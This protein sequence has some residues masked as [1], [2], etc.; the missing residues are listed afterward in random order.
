M[1]NGRFVAYYRVSTAKQ[2][3]SGLG[4]EAQQASVRGWLNGGDW[5]LVGELVEV[6]SGKRSDNRP[7][8]VEALRLC[9]VHNATLVVAKLDRLAR[10]VAFISA[11]MESSVKFVAVDMPHVNEMVIHILASVAQGEA[12]AISERTKAA[13]AAAK[14]RGVM[15]GNPKRDVRQYASKGRA[16][17]HAV[18]SAKASRR[19]EDLLPIIEDIQ[20]AGVTSLAGIAR[21]LNAREIRA[22]RGGEWSATQVRRVASA[23]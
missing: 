4:L 14:V 5:K 8:L 20:A 19:A 21:E 2:G 10:N 3:Q 12:K 6:E 7:K 18:R 17:S 15:L 13:L 9:R 23:A 22:A 11:L 16:V 1:A